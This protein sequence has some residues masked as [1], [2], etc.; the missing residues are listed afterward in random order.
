MPSQD[1]LIACERSGKIRDAFIAR[2]IR[3]ISCDIEPTQNAGPHYCGDV[4][5]VIDYPWTLVIAHPPCTHTSVSGARHFAAK[6][7]DGR[8][9]CGVS[10]FRRLW[11]ACNHVPRVCFEHPVSIMSRLFSKPHQIIQPW[12]FG[13]GETKATCLWLRGLPELEPTNVVAGRSPRVHHMP[14]SAERAALRS[15]TYQGIAD[16]MADQWGRS[17]HG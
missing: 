6:W 9:A 17:L 3:A 7:G 16:A 8:Q 1:V 4:F 11:E 13:H 2:G 15:E 12:Q 14:P 5:D 10:F